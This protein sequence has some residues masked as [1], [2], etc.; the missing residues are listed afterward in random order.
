MIRR[1]LLLAFLAL[2]LPSPAAAD[3]VAPVAVPAGWLKPVP[4]KNVCM[5]NNKAFEQEQI[6]VSVGG[7][8]YYGCC[9]MCKAMLENDPQARA[10]VD[11]V[12]GKTVD[13]STAVIGADAD[14]K[15]YYFESE[16]NLKKFNPQ[17]A[18]PAQ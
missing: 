5:V 14:G 11:P 12:S 10:A 15:T 16:D 18:E 1:L 4:A 6:A 7:K 17:K 2:T 8:T 3:R 13:K 9:P